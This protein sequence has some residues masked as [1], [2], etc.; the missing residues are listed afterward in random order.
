MTQYN[1]LNVKLSNSKVNKLMSAI[2]SKTQ[3][4]LKLSS[5]M[6][7]NSNDETK[8]PHKLLLADRQVANLCK[9]FAN[10]S[11]TDIMPSRT[12][13]SKMIQSGGLLGR[14]LDLLLKTG[15]SLMKNVIQALS[16]SVLIPFGLTVA[17]SAADAGIHKQILGSGTATPVI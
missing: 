17:A 16:K 12:E 3:V 9:A 11:S 4:V 13:L 6:I 1:T 15:L 8:F 14:L 2:K 7:G 10:K 5:N